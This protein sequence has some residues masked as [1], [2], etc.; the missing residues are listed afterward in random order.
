MLDYVVVRAVGY[1]TSIVVALS[2]CRCWS[3]SGSC[4]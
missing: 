2:R 4:Q 1:F 3:R